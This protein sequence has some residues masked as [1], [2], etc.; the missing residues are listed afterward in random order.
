MR[1]ASEQQQAQALKE[2]RAGR[3][4]EPR[5]LVGGSLDAFAT[6]RRQHLSQGGSLVRE[7]RSLGSVRKNCRGFQSTVLLMPL[8]VNS[9]QLLF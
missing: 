8:S 2:E 1:A 3:L 9:R 5:N 7:I 6:C 4:I